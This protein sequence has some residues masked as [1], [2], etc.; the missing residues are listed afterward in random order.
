MASPKFCHWVP[1]VDTWFEQLAVQQPKSNTE[2][3][4]SLLG[5]CKIAVETEGVSAL[6]PDRIAR[7]QGREVALF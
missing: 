3:V 4:R 5:A 7:E 6:D 1:L 2:I